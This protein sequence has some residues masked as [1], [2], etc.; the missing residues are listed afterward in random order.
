[1]MDASQNGADYVD[2]QVRGEYGITIK[3]AK[4]KIAIL[5]NISTSVS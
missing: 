3:N 2:R 1:M 5:E 4:E